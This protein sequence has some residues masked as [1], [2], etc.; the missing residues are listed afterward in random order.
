M[1]PVPGPA[2]LAVAFTAQLALLYIFGRPSPSA[3]AAAPAPEAQV[4]PATSV[5][6]EPRGSWTLL[7]VLGVALLA[8]LATLFTAGVSACCCW[9]HFVGG[10]ATASV[11]DRD[12]VLLDG[13]SPSKSEPSVEP[14]G[15]S[16]DPDAW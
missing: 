7:E 12:L 13:S 15:A 9:W 5:C 4:C 1:A 11:I 3:P 2:S 8:V 6:P 10:V 14:E 16:F